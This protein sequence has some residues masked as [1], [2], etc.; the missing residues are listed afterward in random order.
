MYRF[1][2]DPLP[3]VPSI[4]RESNWVTSFGYNSADFIVA[5]TLIHAQIEWN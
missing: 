1:P 5:K 3:T 4:A 2:H